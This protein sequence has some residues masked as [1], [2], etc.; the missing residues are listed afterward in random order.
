MTVF[1][2]DT[3]EQEKTLRKICD[4]VRGNG[5]FIHDDLIIGCRG[6]ELFVHAPD[7]IAAND[8]I[9]SLNPKTI[10]PLDMFTLGLDGDDIILKEHDP[11]LESAQIA[12]M[13]EMLVLYNLSGKIKDHRENATWML[14]LDDPELM[15][16]LMHTSELKTQK[17]VDDLAVM[18]ADELC[19]TTFIRTRQLGLKKENVKETEK[20][21]YHKIIMPL[22][23]FLNHHPSAPGYVLPVDREETVLVTK[24]TPVAGSQECYVSYSRLDGLS[25]LVS[26]NYLEPNAPFVQSVPFSID[27]AG[28]CA[29]EIKYTTHAKHIE[30]P[31]AIKDLAFYIPGMS[32]ETGPLT[33]KIGYLYIPQKSAPRALRRVLNLILTQVQHQLTPI[34][35]EE[36]VTGVEAHVID[37]NLSFYN[38]ILA[39]CEHYNDDYPRI[40]IIKSLR[41]MCAL[42]IEKIKNYPF[43]ADSVRFKSQSHVEIA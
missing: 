31:D 24:S 19:L 7:T 22:I 20:D 43:Y 1:Q 12:L 5:G 2:C 18:S 39:H 28:L 13:Q 11:S 4:L 42:Q 10:L 25:S 37:C 26:Y 35:I 41:I 34:Q 27:V 29:F 3:A 40:A 14:L 36:F 8:I 6:V 30:L 15:A 32:V 16:L 33:L 17:S 9:L 23:D 38:D 21:A